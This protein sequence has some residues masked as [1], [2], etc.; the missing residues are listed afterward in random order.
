MKR[1]AASPRLLICLIHVLMFSVS[2]AALGGCSRTKSESKTRARLTKAEDGQPGT[3][4]KNDALRILAFANYITPKVVLSF[5][6]NNNVAVE[7]DFFENDDEYKSKWKDGEG[8]YDLVLPLQDRLFDIL[9]NEQAAPL[10]KALIPNLKHVDPKLLGPHYDKDNTLTIPH[11]YLPLLVLGVR[12]DLVTKP[13]KGLEVFSEDQYRGKIGMADQAD[14]VVSTYM[15]HLGLPIG[16]TDDATLAKVKEFMLKQRPLVK[17]FAAESLMGKLEKGDIVLAL[18]GVGNVD[19]DSF[20]GGE[21]KNIRLVVPETG[22]PIWVDSFVVIKDSPMAEAAQAFL[23]HMLDPEISLLNAQE[24]GLA[25]VN[26]AARAKVDA[27]IRANPAKY[28][29]P[30]AKA[31]TLADWMLRLDRDEATTKKIDALWKEVK[32]SKK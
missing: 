31:N 10:N 18:D 13:V 3:A 32:E 19:V 16:A 26:V 4:R 28:P 24:T 14:Q 6:K 27:K 30:P 2:I 25:T 12:T 21:H 29:P 9:S 20:A 23:N 7:I 1:F 8:G 5:Q 11:V 22:I 17:E 15:L